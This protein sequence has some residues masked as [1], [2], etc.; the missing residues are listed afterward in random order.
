MWN[1]PKEQQVALPVAAT[2][3][4]RELLSQIERRSPLDQ[5]RHWIHYLFFPRKNHATI[6]AEVIAAAGWSVTVARSAGGRA[7]WL[8]TA[9]K[10]AAITDLSTVAEARHSFESIVRVCPG[11]DYDGWEAST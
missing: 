5:P 10:S 8:L 11:S 7:R 6:A 2:S 3:G 9:E 1:K 4:D